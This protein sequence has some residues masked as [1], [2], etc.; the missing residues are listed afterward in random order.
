M[1][2]SI[3]KKKSRTWLTR[4]IRNSQ[5]VIASGDVYANLLY[6]N[7]NHVMP[8][9]AELSDD[10]IHDILNYLESNS[11]SVINE[12]AM[13]NEIMQNSNPEILYGRQLFRQQC[14]S[15]H[16]IY[17]ESYGPALGS[18]TKRLPKAWLI[19][20]VRNSQKVIE[21][22][23]PYALP[24]FNSF[25]HRIMVSMDFLNDEQINSILTYIEFAS[26]LNYSP[27]NEMEHKESTNP[28]VS[29]DGNILHN[30]QGYNNW[31]QTFEVAI[32]ILLIASLSVFGFILFIV[33]KYLRR[34]HRD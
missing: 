8:S 34:E 14:A 13:D 3:T 18:V 24:L 7:Y 17:H 23:D 31:D 29:I 15:C 28:V 10:D 1:L 9:F 32:V 20:F 5:D 12:M 25:N 11:T 4:F 6:R 30:Q 33:N 26:T 27:T 21:G 16:S 19:P 2:A 22:G